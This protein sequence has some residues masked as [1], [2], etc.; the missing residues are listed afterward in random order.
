MRLLIAGLESPIA[1]VRAYPFA[2]FFHNKEEDG[3]GC[4]SSFFI[5]LRFAKLAKRVDLGPLVQEYLQIVNSFEGREDGM[6][7]TMQLV[8][9]KNLPS[10]VFATD[11][12]ENE[13][14][15]SQKVDDALNT[16]E[17]SYDKNTEGQAETPL[18]TGAKKK[19]LDES[20]T[21]P[22]TNIS[23][24]KKTRIC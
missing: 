9:K 22:S 18:P 20:E 2:K 14:K 6:D 17:T 3:G 11:D 16:D 15:S 24:L 10:F 21:S 13:V 23:P 12:V 1:G 8:S 5:A 7:L 4:I 19:P